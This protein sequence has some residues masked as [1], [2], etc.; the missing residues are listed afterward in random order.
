MALLPGIPLNVRVK[1]DG[2]LLVHKNVTKILYS[3][4]IFVPGPCG[5]NWKTIVTVRD[6]VWFSYDDRG[7]IA[8]NP[9]ACECPFGYDHWAYE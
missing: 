2:T 5:G 4:K 8:M 7:C 9:A 6:F 1:C 3:C